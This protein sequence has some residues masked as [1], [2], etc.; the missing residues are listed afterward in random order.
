MVKKLM[1]FMWRE[2]KKREKEERERFGVEM[3]KGVETPISYRAAG[4][5]AATSWRLSAQLPET[6][7]LIF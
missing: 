4:A 6:F 2:R 7:K 1:E 5:R 3:K